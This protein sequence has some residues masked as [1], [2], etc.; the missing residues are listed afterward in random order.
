MDLVEKWSA[1]LPNTESISP[2]QLCAMQLGEV[3]ELI[4]EVQTLRARVAELEAHVHET[5]ALL[6][7]R[8]VYSEALEAQIAAHE[9]KEA[10]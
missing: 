6:E 9:K 7:A 5:D 8:R 3:R 2:T 10:K 1:F 4:T